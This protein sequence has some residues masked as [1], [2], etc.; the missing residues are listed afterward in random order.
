MYYVVSG[1]SFYDLNWEREREKEGGRERC[2][3][4]ERGEEREGG[5]KDRLMGRAS[6]GE[7]EAEKGREGEQGG[8]REVGRETKRERWGKGEKEKEIVKRNLYALN[9]CISVM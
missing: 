2:G 6:D 3:W 7:R 8:G 1:D 4:R 5:W 9:R